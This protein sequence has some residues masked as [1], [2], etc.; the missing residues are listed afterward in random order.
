M[1]RVQKQIEDLTNHINEM[2]KADAEYGSK[3][4]KVEEEITLH[5]EHKRFLDKIAIASK[6]KKPVNQAERKR[7]KQLRARVEADQASIEEGLDRPFGHGSST[8]VNDATFLTQAQ[9]VGSQL[10]RK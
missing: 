4:S 1:R 2:K 6:N 3:I 5:K 10:S 7:M 8:R 9:N